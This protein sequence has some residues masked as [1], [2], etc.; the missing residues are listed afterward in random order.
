[1]P[2]PGIGLV[3]LLGPGIGRLPAEAHWDL[4]IREARQARLLGVLRE[5]LLDAGLLDA[6]PPAPRGHLEA[7]ANLAAYRAQMI[8]LEVREIGRCLAGVD[9][10]LLLLK[11]AAYVLGG[12]DVARGRLPGDVDFMVPREV[13]EDV[14]ARML[15]AGWRSS[16]DDPYD[17]RYYRE[18][19]HELPPMHFP[20]R[21]VEVDLH[22]AISPPTSRLHPDPRRLLAASQPLDGTPW[23]VLGAV[24][25]LLHIALHLF[26]DSELDGRI[27]ELVDFHALARETVRAELTWP[28]VLERASELGLRP[29]LEEAI[30]ITRRVLDPSFATGVSVA[31]KATD[32]VTALSL[33]PLPPDGGVPVRARAA[34]WIGVARYHWNRMPPG[35]LARHAS[36]KAVRV[37]TRR[38]RSSPE[39]T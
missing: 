24:D 15:A 33:M 20:G 13:L 38:L 23:R 37:V 36:A 28:A 11:G 25:R 22:H 34:R 7:A 4:V 6:V 29:P 19:S 21:E 9:A 2:E 16:V 39:P 18:W 17:Q 30:R 10:P 5:R 27:R 26:Q 14:E 32:A 31:T 35:L 1:M 12:L 8:R 3:A